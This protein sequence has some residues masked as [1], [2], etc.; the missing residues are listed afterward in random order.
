M[1]LDLDCNQV[2]F[3]V[4]AF[5]LG[6]FFAS[7]NRSKVYEG[8]TAENVKAKD[9]KARQWK[10]T[11]GTAEVDTLTCPGSDCYHERTSFRMVG[12]NGLRI[13]TRQYYDDCKGRDK[14]SPVCA[15]MPSSPHAIT[16][17]LLHRNENTCSSNNSQHDPNQRKIVERWENGRQSKTGTLT[18]DHIGENEEDCKGKIKSNDIWV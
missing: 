13:N 1:K 17:H 10:P 2:L 7:M 18:C 11:V 6:Y 16:C 8:I 4:I 3:L 12:D 9:E 14:D 5:M 15:N